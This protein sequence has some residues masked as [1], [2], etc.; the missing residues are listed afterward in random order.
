MQFIQQWQQ[1]VHEGTEWREK[2]VR[3]DS[4]RP[5]SRERVARTGNEMPE[6]LMRRKSGSGPK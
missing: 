4:P 2:D 6:Q 5:D 1:R 3:S